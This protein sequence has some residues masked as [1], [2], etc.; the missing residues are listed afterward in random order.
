M[1]RI[2]LLIA[3]FLGVN[4]QAQTITT[5]AGTGI[6]G[7]NGDDQ[8]AITTQL[9]SPGGIAVSGNTIIIA[10]GLN[11]RIRKINAHDSVVTLAGKDDPGTDGDGGPA[12][13]AQLD[14][15][16][17]VA[18]DAKGNI[19]I[20]DKFNHSIRKIN[21]KGIITTI[22]GKG[23]SGY[24]GD[25]GAARY[26]LLNNPGNIATGINGDLFIADQGNYCIRKIDSNGI[27]TTVAGNGKAGYSGDSVAATTAMINA[28]IGIT[29]DGAGNLYIADALNYRIRKVNTAGMITTIAGS[30]LGYTGDNDTALKAK[31]NLPTG[32]ATNSRGEVYIADQGNNAIRKI[33]TNGIITTV[34]GNGNDSTKRLYSPSHIVVDGN[35]IMYVTEQQNHRIRRIVPAPAIVKNTKKPKDNAA[36]TGKQYTPPPFSEPKSFYNAPAPVNRGYSNLPASRPSTPPPARPHSKG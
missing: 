7:Y 35:G 19:Y 9:W 16:A 1:N 21:Q 15:P 29:A 2:I 27:I 10:D 13:D 34:A 28:L 23:Q 32:V 36:A 25:G 24:S 31:L 11:N 22:A 12:T 3:L 8:T 20:S 26:A 4:A 5:I 18:L 14:N 6:A 33:D 30:E 17:G